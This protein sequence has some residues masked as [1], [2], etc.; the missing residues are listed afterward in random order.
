MNWIREAYKGLREAGCPQAEAVYQVA[1]RVGDE[2]AEAVTRWL[3]MA[4]VYQEGGPREAVSSYLYARS[5]EILGRA[6]P[7]V[8]YRTWKF[9]N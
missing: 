9:G 7:S 6:I 5:E 1:S 8:S 2:D 3:G 4:F